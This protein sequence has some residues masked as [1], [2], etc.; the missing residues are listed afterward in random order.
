MAQ[1]PGP[2]H[3]PGVPH[4]TPTSSAPPNG[5]AGRWYLI[6]LGVVIALIGGLFVGLMGRSYLRAREMRG[7]PEVPC[8]ILSSEIE[9][10]RHDDN[11]PLEFR[12]N[13]SFG[14]E[15]QGQARTGDHFTLRG[16]PWSSK[17][18]L[19]DARV[20]KYPV[21]MATTCRVDPAASNFAV[22]KTDS[23]APGYSIWFPALF[24]VGG[25]GIA[26]RAAFG[27]SAPPLGL[28]GRHDS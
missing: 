26:L 25:L 11:S 22:L 6:V 19:A 4:A 1:W 10:R 18:E 27:R 5:Q 17:R 14:Y 9:E 20:A 8:V 15:W 3:A 13:L 12:Q 16:N 21:G 23:L 2:T 24:V 7:W 28:S